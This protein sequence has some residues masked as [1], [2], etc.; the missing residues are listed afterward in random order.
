MRRIQRKIGF[1][2][3]IQWVWFVSYLFVFL[4]PVVSWLIAQLTSAGIIRRQTEAINESL[5]NASYL[6]RDACRAVLVCLSPHCLV[7]NILRQ[8]QREQ[9][10]RRAQD[11]ELQGEFGG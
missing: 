4:L 2:H 3:K 7:Y 10:P 8:E 6:L 9:R 5:L 11:M 1:R